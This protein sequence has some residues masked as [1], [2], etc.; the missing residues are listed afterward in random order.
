MHSNPSFPLKISETLRI[1]CTRTFSN[2]MKS[3]ISLVNLLKLLFYIDCA[4]FMVETCF[5][6]E[7]REQFFSLDIIDKVSPW[8]MGFSLL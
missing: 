8:R 6:K 1:S 4:Y 5:L 2:D 7:S 3:H